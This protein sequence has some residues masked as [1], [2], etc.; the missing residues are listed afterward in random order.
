[1][2]S[3]ITSPKLVYPPTRSALYYVP[4]KVLYRGLY[5]YEQ[6]I[7]PPIAT[8]L[9]YSSIKY[10]RVTPS[11]QVLSQAM[12][13]VLKAGNDRKKSKPGMDSVNNKTCEFRLVSK[14]TEIPRCSYLYSVVG[15]SIINCVVVPSVNTAK[16]VRCASLFSEWLRRMIEIHDTFG[17]RM[18]ILAMSELAADSIRNTFSALRGSNRKAS[19]V[20]T[21]SPA[22]ISYMNVNKFVS[23]CSLNNF[24]AT[25]ESRAYEL[26]PVID[27][28]LPTIECQ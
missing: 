5:P 25:I 13:T 7:L 19:Y 28:S 1:M 15:I 22:M 26:T 9:A 4:A 10:S 12:V 11:V 21:N 23:A 20:G 2:G 14:Y 18:N 8:S 3:A 27:Y 24:I 6:D 16:K 17:F